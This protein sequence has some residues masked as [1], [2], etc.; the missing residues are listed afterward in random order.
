MSSPL[1]LRNIGFQNNLRSKPIRLNNI[2]IEN[3][4]NALRNEVNATIAS[5]ASEITSARDNF[6]SLQDNIHE[7]KIF[8]SGVSTGGVITATGHNYVVIQ[9]GAGIT[10]NGVGVDWDKAQ[11]NTIGT[12]TK[13]RYIVAVANTDGSLSLELGATADDPILPNLSDTQRALG[14]FLQ[15]TASPVV[16]NQ[17]D[18]VD[19]RKQGCHLND[20]YFWK[21]QDAVDFASDTIGGRVDVRRGDYYE[22]INIAGK[23]NI[24]LDF[25]SRAR[26]FRVSD[27]NYCVQSIN[28]TGSVTTGNRIIGGE[29]KGNG[30]QGNKELMKIDFT[31]KFLLAENI[32]DGNTNGT[33]TYLNLFVDNS[34]NFKFQRNFFFGTGGDIDSNSYQITATCTQYITDDLLFIY[35]LIF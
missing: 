7:R 29:F 31:D 15:S 13:E 30:K 21:I 9:T 27:S 10:P 28:T 19:A 22:D 1:N 14:F 8:G 17:A 32:F 4:F 18:I 20:K 12:I 16:V 33:A 6:N 2:D 35:S 5:T 24:T 25:T 11:S 26:V 3:E 23:N 34:D